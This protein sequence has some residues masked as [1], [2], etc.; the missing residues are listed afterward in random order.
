MKTRFE[1]TFCT[2][3]FFSTEAVAAHERDFHAKRLAKFLEA[4]R[5]LGALSPKDREFVEWVLKQNPRLTPA[6]AV[7]HC[8]A[9]G[10][11]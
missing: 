2:K 9:M 7:E 4:E 10:G 8:R 5:V 3:H 1:C 6:E 11:L